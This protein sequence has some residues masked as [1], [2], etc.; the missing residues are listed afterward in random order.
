M[1]HRDRICYRNMLTLLCRVMKLE[2]RRPTL[3]LRVSPVGGS[4]V[5]STCLHGQSTR[6]SGQDGA[7]A[8]STPASHPPIT[9]GTW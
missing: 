8:R 7:A 1:N 2:K 6:A 4:T 3:R 5:T 9:L